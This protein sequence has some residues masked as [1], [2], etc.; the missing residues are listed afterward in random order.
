MSELAER[1]SK[2]LE[3]LPRLQERLKRAAEIAAGKACVYATGSFGRCEASQYSDL[4]LFIVGKTELAPDGKK[5]SL[6][7]RL[8]EIRV[9][10]ELIDATRDLKIP[11]FSGDGQYL[12]HYSVDELTETL[13]KREDDV[14]NTF[15]ARLLLLLE[16]KVLIGGAVYSEVCGGPGRLDSFRGE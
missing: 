4:D 1:R 11:E 3:R 14:T 9:K 5:R 13:G 6:L 7:S 2:M 8:D 15:T 12:T 10:A 16:S